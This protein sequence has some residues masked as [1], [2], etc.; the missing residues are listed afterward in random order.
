MRIRKIICPTDLTPDSGAALRYGL[1]LARAYEAQLIQLYCEPN[2]PTL[3]A[4]ANPSAPVELMREELAKHAGTDQ[5][6]DLAVQSVVVGC[7]DPG[8]CITREAARYSADLI[9]MRSRRRPHRAALLGSV[10]ESVSRTAP[11]PVMVVH[12]D[13]RDWINETD[14]RIGLKRVLVAYDFS[15]YSE[16]ALKLALVIAQEYQAELHLLHVLPPSRLMSPRSP[17]TR[18]AKRAPITRL[19]AACRRPFRMKCT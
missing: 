9:I 4:D 1:A 18:S 13:E 11:C 6:N 15:D 10:A 8:D 16:L 19:R 5:V 2:S 12:S 14:R 7:D 17:G 3:I